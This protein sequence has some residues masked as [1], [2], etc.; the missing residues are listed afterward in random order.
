[1]ARLESRALQT[2]RHKN[3]DNGWQTT[4]GSPAIFVAFKL[5]ISSFEI[6]SKALG[7]PIL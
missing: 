2:S 6:I 1:M 3:H 4:L 5:N 7:Y